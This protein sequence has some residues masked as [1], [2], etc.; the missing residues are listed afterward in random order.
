MRVDR[1]IEFNDKV[2]PIQLAKGDFRKSNY[3]LIYAGWGKNE[4]M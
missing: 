3:S 2:K 1:D 4:V